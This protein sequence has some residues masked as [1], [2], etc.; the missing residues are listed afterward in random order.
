MA[1]IGPTI[2]AAAGVISGM[3]GSSGQKAA[4]RANERIADKQMRWSA[5]MSNTAY[6]R[7]VLDLKAAGLNPMLAYQQGGASTPS[8]AG[9][10]MENEKAPLA[11]GI[12]RG[13]NSAVQAASVQSNI[14]LQ[15]SAVQLQSAQ[16]RK[17]RADAAA[18]EAELPWAAQNAQQKS[19]KLF[20]EARI[21]ANNVGTS[22]IEQALKENDLSVLAPLKAQYQELVNRAELAGLPAAEAEAE[23][24]KSLG[25]D[26]SVGAKAL[27]MLRSFFGGV[28]GAAKN[29][30]SL[31]R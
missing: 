21:L 19:E 18:A 31:G 17:V 22:K 5:D 4:N 30:S 3:Q 8:S 15:D 16:A 2:S 14:K 13:V 27:L 28:T 11:E 6:Q 20:S 9:A 26:G 23:F 10:H 25:K 29:I 12:Q 7:A 1:W 24:W